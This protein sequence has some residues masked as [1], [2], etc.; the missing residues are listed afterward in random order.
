VIESSRPR[1]LEQL[2]VDVHRHMTTR[3]TRVWVSI[4][5]YGRRGPGRNRVAF[6]DDAAVAGGLVAW[7]HAEPRFC[8]DAIADPTT[9]LVAA[10]ACLAALVAGGSWMLDIP[11]AGV[12]A[13]L[14]GPTLDV[15]PEVVAAPPRARRGRSHFRRRHEEYGRGLLGLE[16]PVHLRS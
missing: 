11:M 2:G 12:A 5:G 1:A 4:T 7:E 15:G 13:H 8:A 16:Q 10:A 9:G 14:A 6:G 3:A